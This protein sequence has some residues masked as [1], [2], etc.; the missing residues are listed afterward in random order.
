[1]D[2][3]ASIQNIIPED[4]IPIVDLDPPSTEMSP[5]SDFNPSPEA[6][7]PPRPT[8]DQ[9]TYELTQSTKQNEAHVKLIS[10]LREENREFRL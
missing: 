5:P 6:L 7:T 3:P 9:L 8:L 4:P 2:I 10:E 1:M